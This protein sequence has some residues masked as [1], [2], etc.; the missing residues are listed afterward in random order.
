VFLSQ[1]SASWIDQ[2]GCNV[3]FF[4]RTSISFV[5]NTSRKVGT[6]FPVKSRDQQRIESG[7]GPAVHPPGAIPLPQANKEFR[8]ATE[9][10]CFHLK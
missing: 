4:C 9:L 7:H 10:W 5:Q 1:A 3:C 6:G 2:V 8:A